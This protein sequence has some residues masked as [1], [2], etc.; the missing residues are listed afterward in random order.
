MLSGL[1]LIPAEA[2]GFPLG[3]PVPCDYAMSRPDL[4]SREGARR[5]TL[6]QRPRSGAEPRTGAERR[7]WRAGLTAGDALLPTR[8]G[9]RGSILPS[10]GAWLLS[11]TPQISGAVAGV[12]ARGR[13][14]A[15]VYPRLPRQL[16]QPPP[17]VH[18]HRLRLG[19]A[20]QNTDAM[21]I[22]SKTLCCR[23]SSRPTTRALP[24]FLAKR[25]NSRG[26][27]MLTAFPPSYPRILGI[28]RIN[29]LCRPPASN[30]VPV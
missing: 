2:I 11:P 29:I 8:H 19:A 18:A 30:R 22:R 15:P 13:G 10:H 27:A 5:Q 7:A 21:M 12:A 6:A 9:G 17:R 24:L 14:R 20:R 16:G 3:N 23:E 25:S 1:A 26:A 4:A 28:P